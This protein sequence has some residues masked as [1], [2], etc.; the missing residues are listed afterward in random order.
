MTG[1]VSM[2]AAFVVF[3]LA[4]EAGHF[5]AAKALGIKVSEFFVGFGPRIWSVQRGETEYG[6]KAIPAGG[7]VRIVGMSV[8]ED[9]D[10]EDMGRTY[11]EKEFWKKSVVVLSGIAANFVIA[12][13]IFFGL[14]AV[15][16][17][18]EIQPVV[19]EVRAEIAGSNEIAPA[20]LIG[21]E[22]GD[23]FVSI[24]GE[25]VESWD[26][27][28]AVIADRPGEQ[29][30]IVILRDGLQKTLTATLA[31]IDTG[32]SEPSGYLGVAPVIERVD[33]GFFSA[34]GL[35]GREVIDITGE[36]YKTLWNVFKPTSIAQL[37]QG[38]FGEPV[39]DEIRPVSLIGVAQVGSQVDVLGASTLIAFLAVFNIILGAFNV[40]PLLPLDGGHF[41]I[42]L[43]E[44]ITHKQ[45][46]IRKL[47]PVAATVILLMVFIGFV[48]ILLDIVQP[49][50]F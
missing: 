24:D 15:N 7:Y 28:S 36:A 11:R 41:A 13:L 3:I 14:L 33:V 48:S 23:E 43:Y 31:S 4:H 42:A 6:V 47:I 38:I 34:A 8:L 20:A 30:D 26:E 44:K 16:G 17:R 45:A 39:P 35:A 22:S 9:V 25:T 2:L 1:A 5:F 46:D 12:Y 18:V 10:P 49:I 50:R 19:E 32:G 27:V 21:L 29:V 37:V 40:L